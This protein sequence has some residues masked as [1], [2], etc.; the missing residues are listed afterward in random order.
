MKD[1][2]IESLATKFAPNLKNNRRDERVRMFR[3]L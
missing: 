2:G 1:C 3:R